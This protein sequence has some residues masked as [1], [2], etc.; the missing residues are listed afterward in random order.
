[1]VPLILDFYQLGNSIQR[2][3]LR[4]LDQIIPSQ[5]GSDFAWLVY[6]L[7]SLE[8]KDG[9]HF[10]GAL[11]QLESWA[12]SDVAGIKDRDVGPLSLCYRLSQNSALKQ[13]IKGKIELILKRALTG[14]SGTKFD[15]INDPGQVFCLALAADI[16]ESN[17]KRTISK[18][19]ASGARGRISRKALFW[20]VGIELNGKT[21]NG[22]QEDPGSDPD[23]VVTTLW[24]VE[25]YGITNAE[26]LWESLNQVLPALRTTPPL[27]ECELSNR[28]LALLAEATSAEISHPD[29][30]MLFGL[31]PFESE[32]RDVANDYFRGRKYASAV[33]EATKKINEFIQGVSG[34]NK[35]EAD[36]IQA[37]MKKRPP[38]IKFNE[39]LQKQSGQNEQSGLALIAEGIFRAFRNPKGHEPEGHPLVELNP[40]EALGQL[41]AI[42]YIW[43]RVKNAE[44][45]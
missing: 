42:D 37:T 8:G 15:I 28:S 11:K 30:N 20:A 21:D 33:F 4:R 32:V 31:F 6:G 2:E 23:D 35:S 25:R 43:K 22:W 44:I 38:V 17:E 34:S 41:I 1:M 40:Y 13:T 19:A 27:Q 36:L 10:K 24:L 39:Y 9:P 12:V 26:T 45:S 16:L 5:Y 18:V 14:T 7:E 3:L 29:P